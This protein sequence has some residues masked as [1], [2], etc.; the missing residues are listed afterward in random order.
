[1]ETKKDSRDNPILSRLVRWAE[2]QG[3]FSEVGRVMGK[4]PALFYNWVS[5]N[6]T[7]SLGTLSE[8]AG[9]YPELDLNY[10]ITGKI[11]PLIEENKKLKADLE[12]QEAVVAR[13]VGKPEATTESLLVDDESEAFGTFT[14]ENFPGGIIPFEGMI[15]IA[16]Y[17]DAEFI[18]PNCS[19]N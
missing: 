5:R 14:E 17:R 2:N 8:I 9:V 4:N 10:I 15:L 1:M 18:F 13:L 3:G 6:Q 16:K 19:H 7:P 11:S 12:I